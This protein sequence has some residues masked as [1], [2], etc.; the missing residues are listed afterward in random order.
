MVAVVN[1]HCTETGLGTEVVGGDKAQ[2]IERGANVHGG[3]R[4]KIVEATYIAS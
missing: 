2:G 3:V 4:I 1:A